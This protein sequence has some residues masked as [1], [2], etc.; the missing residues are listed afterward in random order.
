MVSRR[1]KLYNLEAIPA[2][3]ERVRSKVGRDLAEWLKG[4]L[5]DNRPE[6]RPIVIYDN[7]VVRID[8]VVSPEEETVWLTQRQIAELYETTVPN[9]SM[10]ISNI[11]EEGEMDGSVIKESLNTAAD[12]KAYSV[13]A[14][15]LDM[16]LAVGFRVRSKRAMEFRRWASSVFKGFLLRG[17]A[18][19]E[20]R[21][22]V[23]DENFLGLVN[24]VESIDSRVSKLETD[25][26]V[27]NKRIFFDGAYF[28]A[29]AYLKDLFSRAEG[30]IVLIDP[31]ADILALDFLRQKKE[32][33]AVCLY[34]SSHSRLTAA[35]VDS[36]NGQYGGLSVVVTDSFHDRFI[37]IDEKELYYVGASLNY[38]G[39]RT[40]MMAKIE[41]DDLLSLLQEKLRQSSSAS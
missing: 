32:G 27:P 12:G 35:D 22:L 17:Y 38:A 25:R 11:L 19:D 16:V 41:D 23:T 15:N 1:R 37:V 40:F 39:K 34:V 5:R 20:R 33:V 13:A 4:Y 3:G 26:F 8:V 24:R 36:F 31:Y 28:D 18:I 7:G 21:A 14:Y 29:R 6:N 10:H 2:L 9:V 30:D